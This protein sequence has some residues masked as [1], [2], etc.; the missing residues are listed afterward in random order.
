[1]EE[2]RSISPYSV[3]M[4]EKVGPEQLRIRTFFM[5]WKLTMWTH[6][7]YLPFLVILKKNSLWRDFCFEKVTALWSETNLEPCQ[8]SMMELK[9]AN[10]FG[11][12][13]HHGVQGSRYASDDCCYYTERALPI[14]QKFCCAFL[15][16]RH[17]IYS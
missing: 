5:Q 13:L 6:D 7:S 11:K 4:Q 15:L 8:I 17:N 14:K 9:S 3:R 1:M 16:K 10:Y 2:L 12:K